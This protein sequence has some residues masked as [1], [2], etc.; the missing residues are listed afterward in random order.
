M[1]PLVNAPREEANEYF[2]ERV[3]QSKALGL[4]ITDFGGGRAVFELP[5]DTKL[6]GDPDSGVISGGAITTLVDAAC[7]CAILTGLRTL[8]RIVTLDLRI[9]Y[10]RP[11]KPGQTVVCTAECYRYTH[12]VAFVRAWAHDGNPE[13]LLATAAGTFVLLEE[14]FQKPGSGGASS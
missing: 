8:R 7:G 5:Y 10:L 9:D 11:G 6:V 3:P 13:D 1:N 2:I 12:E 14:L 4:R